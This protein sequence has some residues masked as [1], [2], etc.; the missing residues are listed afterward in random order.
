MSLWYD[1]CGLWYDSCGLRYDSCGLW[2]DS[3]GY[4]NSILNARQDWIVDP[5]STYAYEEME[6]NGTRI[7]IHHP[8]FGYEN[9]R[10]LY[11]TENEILDQNYASRSDGKSDGNHSWIYDYA[12][13]SCA[14]LVTIDYLLRV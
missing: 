12:C 11:N 2:Y 6:S 14:T 1:S 5:F 9:Q 8:M 7:S 3:C 13:V 4:D 10:D